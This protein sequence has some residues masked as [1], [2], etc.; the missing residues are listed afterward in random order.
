MASTI[1]EN[2]REKVRKALKENKAEL[3]IAYG[4]GSVPYKTKP[5]FIKN[6]KD[7][8]KIVWNSFCNINLARYLVKYPGKKIGIVAKGCDT[9][10]IVSLIKEKKVNRDNICI[11]GVS[12]GGMT[13]VSDIDK[14]VP[15]SIIDSIT[16]NSG[17][18]IITAGESKTELE[19]KDFIN[20]SCGDCIYPNPVISDETTGEKVTPAKDRYGKIKE[21][22]KLSEKERA[23]Y[24]KKEFDKCIRCY[25]CRE[26]CPVC[27]CKECFTDSSEPKWIDSGTEYTDKSMYLIIRAFHMVGRCVDC[28]ACT[29][30]CPK[31]VDL[32]IMMNKI[33][34]DLKDNFQ[35]EAGVS[36]DEKIPLITYKEDDFDEFVM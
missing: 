11:I 17:K 20:V 13:A 30:V 7:A 1:Q 4:A 34:S 12:C 18:I 21:F 33:A 16:E 27:Y 10:A 36:P 22:E 29:R 24:F 6:E 9:R 32:N 25:A 28:G 31:G 15:V 3:V 26:V 35:F 19:R 2:I 14:K 5:L 23:E 8:D